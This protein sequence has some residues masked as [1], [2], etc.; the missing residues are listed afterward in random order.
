MGSDLSRIIDQVGK[1]KGIDKKILIEALEQALLA[2]ARKKYGTKQEIEA[3]FN[4]EAG[5]VELFQFKTVVKDV[6]NPPAEISIKEA[7]DLDADVEVGDSL[8]TKIDISEFGRIA[9]QTA[10]QVIIQK[11]REAERDVVYTDFETRKGDIVHG[12]VLRL[13]GPHIVVSVGK[14]EAILLRGDQV[15]G[16]TFRVGDRIRAYVYDVEK[17]GQKI[18][19]CLTRAATEFVRRLFELEVPEIADK[20]VTI[21]TVAREPGYRTKVAVDSVNDRVDPVGACVGVRGSRIKAIV[22]ELNGEK[23]DIIRWSDDAEAMVKNSLKPAEIA[24]IELDRDTRHAQ[25]YVLRDKLS[26]AIGKGGQNVRLASKM[27][28]WEIDIVEVVEE[29]AAAPPAEAAETGKAESETS[30]PAPE[31]T[32]PAVPDAPAASETPASSGPEK[33]S[34]PEPAS[35]P[36]QDA[37]P[38]QAVEPALPDP[39]PPEQAPGSADPGSPAG[40]G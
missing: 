22:D 17:K 15:P 8:G 31:A 27:T 40:G 35:A 5:E 14:V 9:A 37:P 28:G 3:K 7:K 26:L 25:V 2:A 29:K 6:K 36:P 34:E 12:N 4:E 19:V 23:V 16:E 11:I 10:K 13:E 38:A 18:R 33:E 20:T 24:H 21:R 32:P 39:V 30:A 1:D